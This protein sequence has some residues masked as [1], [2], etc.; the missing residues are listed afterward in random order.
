MPASAHHSLHAAARLAVATL[1]LPITASAQAA[2]LQ[3]VEASVADVEGAL[4]ANTITCR[5]LVD[6]YLARIAAYDRAG[7]ALNA[8]VVENPRVR[9]EADSLDRLAAAGRTAGPLHCVPVIVKD[10]YDTAGLQ[11]TGGSLALQGLEPARDATVVARL[12]AAGALVLAKSNMAELAFSPY[13]TVSS[14]L[15]GYTRNPYALNRV[16]AGSSGGTAAAVAASFGLVGLGTD[17]GNSIRGP[18]AHQALVGLR[19]TMG[20]VSRAG[21]VPLNLWA[22]VTGPMTRTVADAAAMLQVIAGPD[23]ADAATLASRGHVPA[24]YAASLAR[25]G[26]HGARI[27]VLRQAYERAT[28]DPEVVRVFQAALDDL[29]RQG[30][31]IVDSVRVDLSRAERPRGAP[32]SSFRVELDAYLAAHGDRAPVPTLDSLIRTRRFHPSI[33]VRLR[34]ALQD[35]DTAMA[36]DSPSCRARAAY[37]DSVRAA[38]TRAMDDGRLDVLVY[39]TWSNA[40]RLIGDLNTPHGDNNQFFAPA[41]GLPAITVP[42]GW[43]RDG[44]LPAG[45][46]LLG[47]AWAEPTLLKLAYAYEQATRHRRPPA[48]TPALRD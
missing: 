24:S 18:S 32:C 35:P 7:P 37:R 29:R 44:T 36:P 41:P 20:L 46:Q 21:V 15:P 1:L 12:R 39:P 28:T 19:P 2:P 14:I 26:L 13:E 42:M 38:V 23:T 33:E 47:R 6:A 27:G 48:T 45:L 8:I 9:A 17:T 40:P 5:A 34:N 11:T 16:T 25:D 30:A 22:D 31:T 4:R 3:P 43:L 10:N